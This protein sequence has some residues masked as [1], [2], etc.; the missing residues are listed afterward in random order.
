MTSN[1]LGIV[2]GPTLMLP[3]S[4]MNTMNIAT[5]MVAQNKIVELL[6]ANLESISIP[7]G[8]CG[9]LSDW[10]IWF[11]SLLPSWSSWFIP[12]VCAKVVFYFLRLMN[13]FYFK[14]CI[15]SMTYYWPCTVSCSIFTFDEVSALDKVTTHSFLALGDGALGQICIIWGSERRLWAS[16][17]ESALHQV[18][19]QQPATSW[20]PVSAGASSLPFLVQSVLWQF[21]VTLTMN[22]KK[23]NK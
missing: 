8:P 7:C 15:F 21:T 10:S 3:P 4:T 18:T 5:N 16:S 22:P 11:G 17:G 2:F 13:T 9:P 12:T 6:I 23:W 19:S 14:I 20:C 1:N